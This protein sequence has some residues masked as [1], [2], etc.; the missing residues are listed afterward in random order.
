MVT[1]IAT[2]RE[3]NQV[4]NFLVNNG[5]Q[6]ALNN[7]LKNH[8]TPPPQKVSVWQTRPPQSVW[9]LLFWPF[10]SQQSETLDD[11][12]ERTPEGSG[13]LWNHLE[14]TEG[15]TEYRGTFREK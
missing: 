9:L 6:R 11:I 13:S 1:C 15:T 14:P 12:T 3:G 2:Q 7:E 8:M 4:L 5:H 10:L